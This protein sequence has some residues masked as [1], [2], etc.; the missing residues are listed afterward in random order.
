MIGEEST[1][2]LMMH[3]DTKL[4]DVLD[5]LA[6]YTKDYKAKQNYSFVP[7]VNPIRSQSVY[8]SR[9]TPS[10][11]RLF[12]TDFKEFLNYETMANSNAFDINT[13]VK[14]LPT[15]ELEVVKN[16]V[17][18]QKNML[19]KYMKTFVV[20]MIDSAIEENK[21]ILSEEK[22]E[23]TARDSVVGSESDENDYEVI[24]LRHL[25]NLKY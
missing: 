14:N 9:S 11:G 4:S 23:T 7:Y 21:T 8:E 5:K 20:P 24:Y 10:I 22:K 6:E 1:L 3:K 17:G 15:N 18:T 25:R 16:L 13:E 12:T 19:E 2:C